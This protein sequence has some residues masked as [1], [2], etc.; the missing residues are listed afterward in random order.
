M[1]SIVTAALLLGF[2]FATPTSPDPIT[3]LHGLE[4]EHTRLESTLRELELRRAIPSKI[5][6]T[7]QRITES[8]TRIRE[9]LER[10][11]GEA[12]RQSYRASELFRR[13]FG[14]V[15]GRAL[16]DRS[17]NPIAGANALQTITQTDYP[18]DHVVIAR[19]GRIFADTFNQDPSFKLK[20]TVLRPGMQE[21]EPYPSLE[22][23]ARFNHIHALKI[24]SQ[25]RLLILDSG[26]S[27]KTSN[28]HPKIYVYDLKTGARL[29]ELDYAFPPEVGGKGSLFNDLTVDEG[30]KH[31][32]LTDTSAR[33]GKPALV[34]YDFAHKRSRRV[35]E[36]HA[37]VVAGPHWTFFDSNGGKP[38]KLVLGIYAVR[39][40]V[41]GIVYDSLR[42]RVY[43]A[44]NNGGRVFAIPAADLAN[45][46]LASD[47]IAAR[48]FKV[49]ETP[50]TDGM[51]VDGQGRLYLTDPE[52]SA[53]V[54]LDP[55]TG[56]LK[57]LIREPGRIQL[58]SSLS[59]GADGKL[60]FATFPI[61][62]LLMKSEA[63]ILRL[64]R[65]FPVLAL[66]VGQ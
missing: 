5:K 28:V 14:Y 2:A 57:T 11:G 19:D 16:P 6:S 29:P 26:N 55:E 4:L 43:Y 12:L 62:E 27:T 1:H 21:F 9:H 18:R 63:Q 38:W 25:D 20:L 65:K 41:D 64:K 45:W 40:A 15:S 44:P 17:R 58:I 56:E 42:D 7:Q 24:D 39:V 51:T 32:Y 66:T 54:R 13:E 22:E 35:L 49:A 47:A 8:E 37:S 30:R 46:E 36:K 61:Q 34:V 10:N 53:V 52:H 50:M 60:Y 31:V 23:Q 59:F 33:A 48:V 3:A